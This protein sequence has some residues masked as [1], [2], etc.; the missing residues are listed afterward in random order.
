MLVPAVAAQSVSTLYNN[1]TAQ[2]VTMKGQPKQ[3]VGWRDG[4]GV[5]TRAPL[6]PICLFI[7]HVTRAV[8]LQGTSRGTEKLEM[9]VPGR[10]S[11]WQASVIEFREDLVYF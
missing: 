9:R 6:S 7:S 5:H 11:S 2:I 1:R 10:G 3:Q 4:R 8:P